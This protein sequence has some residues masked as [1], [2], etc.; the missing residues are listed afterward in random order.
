MGPHF[1]LPPG[2]FPDSYLVMLPAGSFPYS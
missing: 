2:L 1:G